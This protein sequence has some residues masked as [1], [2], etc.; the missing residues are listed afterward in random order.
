MMGDRAEA[1]NRNT[2]PRLRII[3]AETADASID[4]NQK[5]LEAEPRQTENHGEHAKWRATTDDDEHYVYASDG[6]QS[7]RVPRGHDWTPANI[8]TNPA[9]PCRPVFLARSHR[10]KLTIYLISSVNY[11][12]VTWKSELVVFGKTQRNQGPFRH[13]GVLLPSL[14]PWRVGRQGKRLAGRWSDVPEEIE[15]LG[16]P[17]HTPMLALPAESSMISMSR[18][19]S[20]PIQ[21]S[22]LHI[23]PTSGT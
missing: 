5:A 18:A 7:T 13:P 4:P 6:L 21:A 8:A 2:G 12:M 17:S 20:V 16:L 3:K 1:G 14:R 23:V 11:R 22:G 15:I 9:T 19:P 10:R